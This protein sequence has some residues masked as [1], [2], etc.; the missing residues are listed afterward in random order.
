MRV[1]ARRELLCSGALFCI[2]IGS[3]FAQAPASG[4][5]VWAVTSA[6]AGLPPS[7]ES[8]AARSISRGPAIRQISPTTIVAA[9]QPFPLKVEFAGRGGEKINPQSVQ[10]TLL[11]GNNINITQRL[12]P[13]LSANGLDIPNALVPPGNF[14]LQ[15]TLRDTG[16]RE[17]LANI[18]IAAR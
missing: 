7:A 12:L 9:N 5:A 13:Y 18:E 6:E 11:R 8:T 4:N 16:G 1:M 3:S 10:I 2:S 14:V 17:G 15:V